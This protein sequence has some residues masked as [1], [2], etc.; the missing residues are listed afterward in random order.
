MLCLCATMAQRR[1]NQ[2]RNKGNKSNNNRRRTGG[3]RKSS[4]GKG[5][6]RGNSNRSRSSSSRRPRNRNRNR[7]RSRSQGAPR[8]QPQRAAQLTLAQ[9][10][11]K[12]FSSDAPKPKALTTPRALMNDSLD[13]APAILSYFPEIIGK[14]PWMSLRKVESPVVPRRLLRTQH[15]FGSNYVFIKK[16]IYDS[17]FIAEN[18]ARKLEFSLAPLFEDNGLPKLAAFDFVGSEHAFAVAQV[19]NMLGST[20]EINFIK[21]KVDDIAA[22]QIDQLQ[23]MGCRL[24]FVQSMKAYE[25]QLRW[26]AYLAGFTKTKILPLEGFCPEACLGYISAMAE[27][28]E[29]VRQ[30]QLSP[31]DIIFVPVYTGATLAGMEIGRR[32]FGLESDVK[33]I[34]IQSGVFPEFSTENLA[35]T[36][37][38]AI[39]LLNRCLDQKINFKL[40]AKDFDVVGDFSNARGHYSY[41]EMK[42]WSTRIRELEDV[43]LQTD[44]SARALLGMSE[45]IKKLKLEDKKI[46]FWNTYSSFRSDRFTADPRHLNLPSTARAWKKAS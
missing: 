20:A 26:K 25:F 28:K 14:L 41:E 36:G 1:S 16:E 44:G 37:N 42:R 34:G 8:R 43:E 3:G 23:K 15:L 24:G 9:R 27:I 21:E 22:L 10:I 11:K 46:L 17:D 4:R 12:W 5:R 30:A 6:N 39:Q 40:T 45:I 18:Q 7:S 32:L 29:Q 35:K 19:M 31:I 38:E 2:G 13:Y 33:I